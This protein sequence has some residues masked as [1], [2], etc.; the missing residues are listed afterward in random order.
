MFIDGGHYII[1]GSEPYDGYH[2]L[3]LP[4]DPPLH[5][6]LHKVPNTSFKCNGRNGYYADKETACQV[7]MKYEVIVNEFYFF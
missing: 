3:H 7:C 1:P 2:E 5:P 4:H 6:I